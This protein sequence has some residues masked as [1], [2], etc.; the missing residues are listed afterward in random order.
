MRIL[1][2]EKGNV[3]LAGNS[4]LAATQNIDKN[5][6]PENIKKDV[7]IMG[8]V[9]TYGGSGS[10]IPEGE[11]VVFIDY[12][13]TV[14]ASYTPDAFLA[15]NGFPENPE[16][17]GLV[18]QGWNW[19]INDAK[20]YVDAFGHLTIGQMYTTVDGD[21]RLHITLNE[22]RTE[23]VVIFQIFA[24]ESGQRSVPSAIIDWGDGSEPEVVYG[25]DTPSGDPIIANVANGGTR[26]LGD[27]GEGKTVYAPHTYDEAGDYV[28]SI[29]P[30]NNSAIGISG[31]NEMSIV[32]L[33]GNG[34]DSPIPYIG[35]LTNV[36][37]GE[38]CMLGPNAFA[39]CVNLKT[40]TF[41]KSYAY[42]I[43]GDAFYRCTSLS[44]VVFNSIDQPEGKTLSND[45]VNSAFDQCINLR[46]VSFSKDIS[47]LG[48][49]AFNYCLN[50]DHVTL[51][52]IEYIGKE[53]FYECYNIKYAFVPTNEFTDDPG[54]NIFGDCENLK[55]VILGPGTASITQ[56]M[57]ERCISIVNFEIPDTVEYI[58]QNAFNR[59]INLQNITIPEGV[60]SIYDYAFCYCVSLASITFPST[61]E[62][63]GSYIFSNGDL[64]LMLKR[65]EI[66]STTP[67]TIQSDTFEYIPN[68]CLIYV[69]EASKQSYANNSYWYNMRDHIN[70]GLPNPEQILA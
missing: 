32:L 52:L 12:D 24:D 47:S 5:L 69:P 21:T 66:N 36:E 64:P 42:G 39:Q 67:P 29:K 17:E 55:N 15:L 63:L 31:Q 26:D 3:L 37:I 10:G 19:D 53:A 30:D 13:G 65:I 18:A 1:T 35:T 41:P 45:I 34:L 46:Y 61:V 54:N 44:S 28:I 59:C 6:V 58:D 20:Q 48:D 57:F 25:Q 40:V 56:R 22:Y 38:K 50:L 49:S 8:V 7:D 4:V 9:G 70:G 23:P 51:P 16:H 27:L 43:P 62:S 11:T 68:D 33:G 60:R 14:V 2:D